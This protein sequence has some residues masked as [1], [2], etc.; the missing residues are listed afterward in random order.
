M[1]VVGIASP[2]AG[3]L[4]P[5]SPI[6]PTG[7][8]SNTVTLVLLNVF[9]LAAVVSSVPFCTI[10]LPATVLGWPAVNVANEVQ[11]NV[12]VQSALSTFVSVIALIFS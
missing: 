5:K 4:I 12:A 1:I 11:L 3:A 7:A 10:T 9:S 2:V 6:A 8:T